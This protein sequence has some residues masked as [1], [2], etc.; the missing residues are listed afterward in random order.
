MGLF[1]AIKKQP[2]VDSGALKW[3]ESADA[4]YTKALQTH[5]MSGL[6]KYFD[7]SVYRMIAEQLRHNDKVYS[8]LE[9]YKHVNWEEKETGVY[10]K[11][12]T[13]D[14]MQ[15]SKG[16]QAKVGDDYKEEWCLAKTPDG[17]RVTKIR[18]VA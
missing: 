8:G 11:I 5:N 3:L 1:S 4:L 2:K 16:I 18:R 12:V 6:E 15:I 9:R 10:I 17:T 14:Q 13:Y 7:R